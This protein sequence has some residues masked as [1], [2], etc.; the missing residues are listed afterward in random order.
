MKKDKIG[1]GALCEDNEAIEI[2]VSSCQGGA[3]GVI[4]LKSN[5]FKFTESPYQRIGA[6]YC[7]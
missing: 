7:L 1:Y 4:F 2:K 5:W 3:E 6:F